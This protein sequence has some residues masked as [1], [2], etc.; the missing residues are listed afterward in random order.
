MLFLNWSIVHIKAHLAKL[1]HSLDTCSNSTSTAAIHSWYSLDLCRSSSLWLWSLLAWWQS[2]SQEWL[3]RSSSACS[4]DSWAPVNLLTVSVILVRI[5][6]LDWS[7]WLH[8]WVSIGD[9]HRKYFQIPSR[10]H[11]NPIK[12]Q[13]KN[14]AIT[15]E[16]I[17]IH[18]AV[19]LKSKW[20]HT[21]KLNLEI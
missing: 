13:A 21:V 1:S 19:W 12:T 9:G 18:C 7:C 10:S 2:S 5:L 20:K 11:F 14:V 4:G 17:K 8:S 15:R 3:R 16:Q 6:C